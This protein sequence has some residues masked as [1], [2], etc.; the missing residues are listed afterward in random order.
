MRHRRR[1]LDRQFRRR[2]PADARRTRRPALLAGPAGEERRADRRHAPRPRRD[3]GDIRL[4]PRFRRSVERG[5]PR[6]P[7]RRAPE[8]DLCGRLHRLQRPADRRPGRAD[9]RLRLLVRQGPRPRRSRTR[10]SRRSIPRACPRSMPRTARPSGGSQTPYRL[11]TKRAGPLGVGQHLVDDVP[12]LADRPRLPRRRRDLPPAHGFLRRR[13][14]P[15]GGG[16]AADRRA[17]LFIPTARPQRRR[18]Q[19]GP[20]RAAA[21]VQPQLGRHPC[22]HAGPHAGG[23]DARP[24]ALHRGPGRPPVPAHGAAHAGGPVRTAPGVG[25]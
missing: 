20:G 14:G 6:T 13:H 1:C 24:R 12:A 7:S 22:P 25:C 16:L 18:R 19:S 15:D 10:P 9:R 21:S 2:R 8:R 17:A 3:P 11:Y 23:H 4:L 5:F